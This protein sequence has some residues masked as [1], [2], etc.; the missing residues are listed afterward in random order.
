MQNSLIPGLGTQGSVSEDGG[1]GKRRTAA[2]ALLWSR[3]GGEHYELL[4]PPEEEEVE[5]AGEGDGSEK[6]DVEEVQM[7]VQL[8]TGGGEAEGQGWRGRQGGQTEER[9][10]QEVQQVRIQGGGAGRRYQGQE[11]PVRERR[12]VEE[13]NAHD[14]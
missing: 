4:W 12:Q 14:R 5:E 9:V 8:V 2:A 13:S 10:W 6:A 1:S 11:F 3:R 7:E